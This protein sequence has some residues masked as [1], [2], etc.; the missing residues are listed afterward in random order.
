MLYLRHANRCS[1][2]VAVN[3]WV[4]NPHW[5]FATGETYLQI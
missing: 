2:E 1:D 4:D 5:Q 3:T